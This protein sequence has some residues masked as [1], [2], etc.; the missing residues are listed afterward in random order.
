MLPREEMEARQSIFGTSHTQ[1]NGS[2]F[3]SSKQG[4][5][6]ATAPLW[7]FRTLRSRPKRVGRIRKTPRLPENGGWTSVVRSL[8][9]L[10][11][12]LAGASDFQNGC[13]RCCV[14]LASTEWQRGY[15]G[16]KSV[17]ACSE[18]SPSLCIC[19]AD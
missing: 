15:S 4:R 2:W 16:T 8:L 14:G 3:R 10:G 11:N 19:H 13:I 17:P 5:I 7:R 6:S 9:K 1:Q 12:W 18:R